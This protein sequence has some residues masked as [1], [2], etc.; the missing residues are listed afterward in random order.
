MNQPMNTD[1]ASVRVLY[2]FPHKIGAERICTT[3]WHQVESIAAAGA[4]VTLLT[5]AVVRP[6]PPG[7]EVR[8][9]L[10]RGRLQLPYRLV[11]SLRAFAVHD[12]LAARELRKLADA[13]DIIHCWP[14]GSRRTLREA[15]RLGIPTVLERPNAHTRFAYEVVQKECERLGLAM[16]PGHE[17]AYNPT[18]LRFEEEEYALA[19][20]LLC[21]SDFVART[22]RDLG[23]APDRLVRD[24]YGFDADVYHANGRK[25]A[26]SDGLTVLFAGGC[27]PRKGLHF[28]LA[29][30]LKSSAHRRGK[31]RIAGSFIPGYAEYLRAELAHPSV[32]VLGFR[33]DIPD[34][35]RAADILVLPS[36]EEGSA[37]VTSEAR[38]CGC[39]L[40]VSDASG[41]ICE[42]MV[43]ALV[44][45]AGDVEALSRHM[46]MLDQDRGLLERLRAASFGTVNQITW[47]AGGVR[48]VRAY[49]EL[50]GR[51]REAAPEPAAMAASRASHS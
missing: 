45:D 26:S 11:G 5:G 8:Q 3:A 43:N 20:Y 25:P 2:S 46:T 41:A 10:A 7:I 27:Q 37:L 15:Q 34:L 40:L 14:L 12:F 29:A 31:F 36:I 18:V 44:H 50:I 28:A 24:Q 16:P 1:G 38:G 19:D 22:F 47:R 48:L 13:T 30:W 32:E 42:H 21:P 49:R 51:R 35:M 23:F 39:V 6:L 33:R 17:H 9:T 4:K